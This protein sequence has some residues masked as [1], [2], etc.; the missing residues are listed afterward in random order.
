MNIP[1]LRSFR[2]VCKPGE[3]PALEALL[4]A[5]GFVWEDEPFFPLARRLLREPFSLGASLA[6]FFGYVYIQDRSSMLPPL[7][8]APKPGDAVLDMCAS[9]GSKTGLLGQ[10][11]GPHGF[12]LGN[13]PAQSRLATLRR[14]LISLNL[15]CC[16]TTS[17]PGERL[18]L[19][20]AGADP[21]PA[22]APSPPEGARFFD[23]AAG[24][25]GGFSAP[26]SK[27]VFA[28]S[29]A[30]YPGWGRIQLDPPCSGWGTV[31]KNPQVLRLWRGDK[32]KP[33]IG[34]Q[35]LLLR[36]AARLLRPGGRL[37]YS[38]CTTH[39]AENEEQVRFAVDELGLE[40][41]PLAPPPGFAFAEPALPEFS[42]V[43][44]VDT[45]T[46]GQGFFVAALRKPGE[47][48]HPPESPAPVRSQ[49]APV[50]PV[51]HGPEGRTVPGGPLMA[52]RPGHPSAAEYPPVPERHGSP[53]R[54]KTRPPAPARSLLGEVL[55]SA[56]LESPWTDLSLLPPGS[57]AVFGDVPH[58][59]PQA[60][61][62]LLPPGFRWKGFPLGRLRPGGVRVSPAL[63]V[64]MPALEEALARG[65][66]CLNLEETAPLEA[67]LA[68]KALAVSAPGP[69]IGL[70]FQGLPLCRL[71]VKGSRALL[72]AL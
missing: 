61:A 13:E 18:P 66:P 1:P 40:F 10:M 5:Q 20:G 46:D 51:P 45:G 67:L 58:F 28:S 71:T 22:D 16:A 26:Q 4:A 47:A 63:R 48:P 33:L 60:S 19:P 50:P 12:V 7:A 15:L 42:G 57:V 43:L 21:A 64:L 70:Y 6:A 38:T 25:P 8:L 34:L 55:P 2:L 52:A 17:H 11:V 59:L 56:A 72:P 32:V 3:I 44:R 69:E 9:P 27:H 29:R 35:R 39:T 62:A 68:G 53:A 54:R 31:E 41:V 24:S 49:T 14:N 23:R 37:V 36:E 30:P 65:L